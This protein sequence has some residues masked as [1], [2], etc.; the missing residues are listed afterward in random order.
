MLAL[1]ELR[2]VPCWVPSPQSKLSYIQE[3]SCKWKKT[4][5]YGAWSNTI[6]SS[7]ERIEDI[8]TVELEKVLAE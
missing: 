7:K 1:Q 5:Y 6:R 8:Q 3:N 4:G 2:R